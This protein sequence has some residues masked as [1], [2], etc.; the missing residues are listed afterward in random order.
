MLD[1]LSQGLPLDITGTL[2]DYTSTLPIDAAAVVTSPLINMN[3]GHYLAPDI[4]L[5]SSFASNFHVS[6]ISNIKLEEFSHLS[7]NNNHN[8][9]SATLLRNEDSHVNKVRVGPR[10]FVGKLSKDTIEKDLGDYFSKYGF[11]MDVYIPR[12][13][14]NKK[15][16]RG[17][18]FVTFETEAAIKRVIAHG[19]HT[20]KGSVL[21]IDVAKPEDLSSPST[22]RNKITI[23][24]SLD[25]A[26]ASTD[27]NGHMNTNSS[28]FVNGAFHSNGHHKVQMISSNGNNSGNAFNNCPNPNISRNASVPVYRDF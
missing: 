20:L 24:R 13:R 27:N 23:K 14:E 21:A 12:S 9:G 19:T 16:H 17:F 2:S 3:L 1:P 4:Q 28:N 6:G 18:G 8:T 11:V 5:E 10:I 22:K 7:P 25:I 26:S 15:E